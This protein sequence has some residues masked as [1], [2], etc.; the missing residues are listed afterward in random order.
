MIEE[1]F[2]AGRQRVPIKVWASDLDEQSRAQLLNLANLPMIF[3]HVAAMADAHV[4]IGA[5]IGSVFATKGA[6]IP[7]AV[8][9]DIGCGICALPTEVQTRDI[10][11]G[12]FH[13]KLVD[14]IFQAIPT[15]FAGHKSPQQ[16]DAAGSCV[17]FD[18]ESA[19]SSLTHEIQRNAPQK[20]GTLGGGNHFIELQQDPTGR[21]WLMIHSGS[22]NVGKMIA[23]HYMKMAKSMTGR[24]APEPN[25]GWLPLDDKAGRA[26]LS[27]MQW[28]L[29]Y[30]F[31]NR[32]RMMEVALDIFAKLLKKH[33]VRACDNWGDRI[34]IH[35][36]FVAEE[37]H[38]GHR[39]WVHRKGATLATR[40]TTGIIPG[41]MGAPSYI[42]AGLACPDSFQSCSHGAGRVL[43]RTAAKR[44]ISK[45]DLARALG[46]VIVRHS[47]DVR[48]EAP[49]AYK[50]IQEVMANQR[51]LVD[52]LV[53]LEPL[54]TIKG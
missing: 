32:R 17:G 8:G 7:S 50:N 36:N 19:Y 53:K 14:K 21:L 16:W 41:S 46:K 15:G 48:D 13:Q 44:Q 39:V 45:Q 40:E 3:R 23:D 9:V 11:A 29:N 5:T 6:V 20:L 51:D 12:D 38:F 4:G 18:Y 26:Y 28:A 22:R 54:A 47:G 43:S 25:L 27:D 2:Q 33:G 37:E 34:D 52:I 49:Q 24:E 31:E 1:I 35:H 10:R 30:A 42:V